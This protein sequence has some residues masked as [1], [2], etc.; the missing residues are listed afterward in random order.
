M[1][2]TFAQYPITGGTY[3][4]IAEKLVLIAAQGTS[5]NVQNPSGPKHIQI[6]VDGY[7]RVGANIQIT[8][9][10]GS[11]SVF[12]LERNSN[13]INQ[14]FVDILGNMVVAFETVIYAVSGDQ[15]SLYLSVNTQGYVSINGQNNSFY[16]SALFAY[17]ID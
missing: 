4:S 7:Y 15:I 14:Y 13:I 9:D 3:N 1:T 12:Y 6:A 11:Q 16:P 17:L 2:A 8:G 5:N 10:V